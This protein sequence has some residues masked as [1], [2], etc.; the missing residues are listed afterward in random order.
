MNKKVLGATTTSIDGY[1][2]KSKLEA[3]AYSILKDSGLPFTY[4]PV[5]ITVQPSFR[6]TVPFFKKN[7]VTKRLKMD[8]T[9]VRGIT[10]TPDFVVYKSHYTIY[11][12]TK[13]F[14]TDS[15]NIKVK[16][17]RQWLENQ[18]GVYFAEITSLKELRELIEFINNIEDVKH[19]NDEKIIRTKS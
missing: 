15:Y 9:M 5:S 12:E 17:F 3:R 8:S 6:P 4:T 13:G 11:I 1:K 18:S 10:Y 16:L 19:F 14:K 7:K 2:F